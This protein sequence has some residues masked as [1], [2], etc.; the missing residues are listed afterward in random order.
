MKPAPFAWHPAGSV[1]EAVSVLSADEDAKL[2]AGGQS[3][4]PLLSLRL[5]RPT[6]LVDLEDAGLGVLEIADGDRAQPA[7]SGDSRVLVAGAMVRQR[8]LEL[9]PLVAA[10]VPLL[11][12]AARHVGFPATRNRGTLGGSLAH[13]DP[14]AELPAVA[15]ALD[16]TVVATGPRGER[17]LAASALADGFFATTLEP[18]EVLT[19]VRFPAAGPGHG[20]AWCEWSPRLHDFPDAGVGVAVEL[21]GT[22]A[23]RW[24]GAAACGIGGGPLPL[25][26]ELAATAA[27]AT[28]ATP[29]LLRAAAGA[30][31]AAARGAGDGRDELCGLLAARA[32]AQAFRRAQDRQ[33][34]S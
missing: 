12:D 11:A 6:T 7:A 34:A 21:D 28:E 4:L 3:L 13:A 20:A 19:A 15:V 31:T 5:A 17:R 23:L 1:E 14:V 29:G 25:G 16:A 18:A 9:D 26:D 10:T 33:V 22:G 8:R 32:L 30:V 27:G 24:V 2:L